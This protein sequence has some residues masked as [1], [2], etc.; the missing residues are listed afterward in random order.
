MMKN[1]KRVTLVGDFNWTE[2]KWETFESG[3]K[4]HGKINY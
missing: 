4:I 1:S 2:V 3:V